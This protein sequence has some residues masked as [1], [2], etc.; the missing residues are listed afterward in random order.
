MPPGRSTDDSP[1]G[2]PAAAASP[3]AAAEA[4]GSDGAAAAPV[5]YSPADFDEQLGVYTLF[6]D[7]PRSE[8]VFLHLVMESWEDFGVART[9]EKRRAADPSRALMVVLAVPDFVESCARAL[10]RVCADAGG[11]REHVPEAVRE[12]VRR[13]ILDDAAA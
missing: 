12:A 5:A 7:V 4:C 8:V 10:G 3:S 13:S 6:L 2:V 1:R 9:V 11:R